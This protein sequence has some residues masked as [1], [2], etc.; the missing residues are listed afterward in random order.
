MLV[1]LLLSKLAM[2]L[3]EK[4]FCCLT[5][6]F[7]ISLLICQAKPLFHFPYTGYKNGCVLVFLFLLSWILGEN[8]RFQSWLEKAPLFVVEAWESVETSRQ[9]GFPLSWE[10]GK[11][12]LLRI[13]KLSW[14]EVANCSLEWVTY[15]RVSW[16]FS[17]YNQFC[18]K[19]KKDKL[20]HMK[21]QRSQNPGRCSG[22]VCSV[23]SFALGDFSTNPTSLVNLNATPV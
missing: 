10:P 11:L 16:L 17:F 4:K 6:C 7:L 3:C 23:A 14:H 1:T 22:G 13:S 12:R 18:C 8:K 20:G 5:S 21:A 19:W 2:W 9:S 15:L